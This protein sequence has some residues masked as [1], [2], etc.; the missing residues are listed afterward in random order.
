MGGMMHATM[1]VA[2]AASSLTPSTAKSATGKVTSVSASSLSISGS[3]GG[4]A[5]FTQTFVIDA[6]TKVVGRGAG[7][8]TAKSGGKAVATDLVHD[9]DTVNVSF[10]DM[11]GML[12]ATA[13]TVT[14]KAAAK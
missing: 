10:S 11:N 7:T 5:S 6:K 9:G 12:H 3:S 13:V 14:M 1:I 8:A 4:G 2:V